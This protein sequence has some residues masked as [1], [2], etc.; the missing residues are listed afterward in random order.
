[1]A[2]VFLLFLTALIM[3]GGALSAMLIV[4]A[5]RRK[6]VFEARERPRRLRQELDGIEDY[7]RKVNQATADGELDSLERH[8]EQDKNGMVHPRDNPMAGRHHRRHRRV[9]RG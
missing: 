6:R 8:K 4:R 9:L 5:G 7:I 3:L 2:D 1:M